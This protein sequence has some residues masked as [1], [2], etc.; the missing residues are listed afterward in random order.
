MCIE[1]PRPR[2]HAALAA[3]QLGHHRLRGRCRAPARGRASGRSRSGSR[4]SRSARTAPTIVASSP[5]ARC[6]KPPTLALAYISPARSS[7]RRI[8]IIARQP[9]ARGVLGLGQRALASGGLAAS[10]RPARISSAHS[11]VRGHDT[12]LRVTGGSGAIAR[13][14]RLRRRLPLARQERQSALQLARQVDAHLARRSTRRRGLRAAGP[15]TARPRRC[16]S[17]RP[18]RGRCASGRP[19]APARGRRGGTISP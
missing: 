13:A 6:R 17:R 7:K 2:E 15:R 16:R 9:L 1:P 5:I 18:R 19:A 4:S 14:S 8:S 11:H 12:A 3:E 10:R